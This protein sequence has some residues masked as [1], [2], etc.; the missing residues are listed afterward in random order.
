MELLHG[1]SYGP[2]IWGFYVLTSSVET[3]HWL[4]V[5]ICTVRKLLA[6]HTRTYN[7]LSTVEV[8]TGFGVIS[9]AEDLNEIYAD[10]ELYKYHFTMPFIIHSIYVYT[11]FDDYITEYTHVHESCSLGS[12]NTD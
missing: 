4:C 6:K 1:V 3:V 5:Y 7:F 9:A 8:W 12:F 2:E 11:V 10:E